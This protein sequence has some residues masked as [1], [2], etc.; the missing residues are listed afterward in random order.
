[1]QRFAFGG[2]KETLGNVQSFGKRTDMFHV[3]PEVLV[4]LYGQH[5]QV[6]RSRTVESEGFVVHATRQRRF[7]VS[8]NAEF[9]E[10]RVLAE[11]ATENH[12]ELRAI[13]D[14]TP[15]ISR[16]PESI[17]TIQL[18]RAEQLFELAKLTRH[19]L[20]GEREGM[21]LLALER[22]ARRWNSPQRS[23]NRWIVHRDARCRGKTRC[24]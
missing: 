8:S 2:T 15:A 10:R 14:E 13:H 4:E 17:G 11:V 16:T 6:V 1:M 5:A 20:Q 22:Q 3:D 18:V 19:Y 24:L 12:S 9:Q 21:N 23:V 7:A